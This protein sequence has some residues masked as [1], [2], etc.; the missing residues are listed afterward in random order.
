MKSSKKLIPAVMLASL[1]FALAEQCFEDVIDV[2]RVPRFCQ[3]APCGYALHSPAKTECVTYLE[4]TYRLCGTG[5][6][7]VISTQGYTNGDCLAPPDGE[8]I[9]AV[10]FGQPSV[11]SYAEQLVIG[12]TT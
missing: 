8:C 7:V 3:A 2:E 10:P 9:D 12:C 4:E 5:E 1:S 6:L 11:N